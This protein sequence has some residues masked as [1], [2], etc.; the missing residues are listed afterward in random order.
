MAGFNP[1]LANLG[2]SYIRN[3]VSFRVQFS[4]RDRFLVTYNPTESAK[5]YARKRNTIDLKS[6]YQI[7]KHFDVYLNIDNVLNEYDRALELF[8]GFPTSVIRI[9]PIFHFGV[10][11]RF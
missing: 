1:Q 11:A 3:K 4:H 2:V 9:S 10:N 8:G 5:A 7:S 6:G